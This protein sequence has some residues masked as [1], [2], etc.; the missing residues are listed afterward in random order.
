[1]AA[2]EGYEGTWLRQ[3]WCDFIS[4]NITSRLE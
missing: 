1:M 4:V 3:W 2:V